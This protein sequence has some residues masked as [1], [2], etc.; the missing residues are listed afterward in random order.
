MSATVTIV[1]A[2]AGSGKTYLLSARYIAAALRHP[3]AFRSILAVTFTN[4]A[5]SEMKERIVKQL[6][7]L[8][9]GEDDGFAKTVSEYCDYS[10]QEIQQRAS[11]T[12]S[13]ILKDYSSFSVSTID[14]FFQRI[15]RSFF[16]ELGLDISYEV[17]IDQKVAMSEAIESVI[18]KSAHSSQLSKMVWRIV[19]SKLESGKKVNFQRELD[20]IFTSAIGAGFF[21]NQNA[22]LAEVEEVF[23]ELQSLYK[24][25]KSSITEQCAEACR[26]ITDSGLSPLDFKYGKSSFANY[27]FN[28]VRGGK[29]TA[30]GARFRNIA[31]N[32]SPS[33]AVTLKGDKGAVMAILPRIMELTSSIM[34][35]YD[36]T[37]EVLFSFEAIVSNFSRYTLLR[38]LG[39]ELDEILA[40]KGQLSI[41]S[42]TALLK[43]IV[44]GASVPFIFERLGSRY[45]TIFIDEF[46]DTA[47]SQWDGFLPLV[48]EAASQSNGGAVMI[49]G[50]IK[51]AIYRWRGGDWKLLGSKVEEDLK[52]HTD[53]KTL[54]ISWRSEENI[55]EFNN[56]VLRSVVT[57]GEAIISKLTDACDEDLAKSL[58][59]TLP[60][61]YSDLEQKSAP[62]RV[63]TGRGYVEISRLPSEE[64]IE[65]AVDRIEELKGRYTPSRIGILV[66]EKANGNLIAEALTARGVEFMSEELLKVSNS[67]VV[68]FIVN[69]MRY[70]VSRDAIV[71]RAMEFYL[72]REVSKSELLEIEEL[73]LFGVLEVVERIVDLFKLNDSEL[74]YLQTLYNLCYGYMAQGGTIANFIEAWDQGLMESA[75]VLPESDS[76]VKIMTIHKAKGLE[77]DAVVLPFV[78]WSLSPRPNSYMWLNSQRAPYSQFGLYPINFKNELAESVYARDYYIEGVSS[79]VD[80]INLLYVALTRARTEL[81]VGL[82]DFSTDRKGDVGALVNGA[83]G[84]ILGEGNTYG[85][86]PQ[87]SGVIES[88]DSE[89]KNTLQLS[90]FKSYSVPELKISAGELDTI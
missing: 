69:V 20:E 51:Q 29:V 35:V 1:R 24:E 9:R 49:I 83:V 39:V 60:S 50:D 75:V 65:W 31:E 59:D 86:K 74:Y 82:G 25:I 79:I 37:K 5:T 62:H 33:D 42:T 3:T 44:E 15:I 85:V 77:F 13:A 22:E 52:G 61:A 43:R 32:Q 56:R 27:F 2:S 64:T 12:L 23:S 54:N 72:D 76:A 40:Q 41:S 58:L 45:S 11:V 71:M 34:S 48:E 14:K 88:E 67:A 36:Q 16:K 66:R 89:N 38:Q 68:R 47:Q 46:Q 90:Q 57:L 53:V 26:L 73:K 87:V 81:Y 30:P 19:S 63:G 6:Y 55:V 4:K 7:L 70:S 8:S 28:I 17:V 78:K 18:E 10:P 84:E 21:T 80:N